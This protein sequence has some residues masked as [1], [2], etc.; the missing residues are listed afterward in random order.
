MNRFVGSLLVSVLPLCVFPT[1]IPRNLWVSLE[2]RTFDWELAS[3][4]GRWT[5]ATEGWIVAISPGKS[6]AASKAKLAS[7]RGVVKVFAM[8]PVMPETLLSQPD[9][10]MIRQTLQSYKSAYKQYAEAENLQLKDRFGRIKIPGTG[11]LEAW[12]YFMEERSFP[13]RSIDWE[14]Y[15]R[16][17]AQRDQMPAATIGRVEGLGDAPSGTWQPVGPKN[18]DVPYRIYWGLRPV[19]GRINGIAYDP[20]DQ[21]VYYVASAGGGVWKTTDAGVNWTPLS[22]GWSRLMTSCVAVDPTNR[23]NVYVGTGDHHG[24]RGPGIG[25][26]KSTNQGLSFAKVGGTIFDANCIADILIDPENPQ[27][28]VVASGRGSAGTNRLYRSVDGG[29][30]F[31]IVINQL[32]SWSDLTMGPNV[33][34]TRVYYAAGGGT[35]GNVWKSTDRGATWTKLT[36]PVSTGSHSCMAIAGSPVNFNNVYLLSPADNN[37]FR[38]LDAGATWTA[39]GGSLPP[40]TSWGQDTYDFHINCSSKLGSVDVVYVGLIDIVQSANGGSSWQSVGGPTP[41]N[42]ALTHNDQHGFAINPQNPDE[43][44]I[45]NDGG[46]YRMT[47]NP[48]ANTWSYGY[49]SKNICVTTFYNGSYHP[50]L[51]DYMMGGTQDN[52]TPTALGDLLNWSNKGGGDGAGTT[53]LQLNGSKQYTMAQYGSPIYRTANLWSTSNTLSWSN[54]GDSVPFIPTAASD[55]SSTNFFYIGSNYLYRYS[56]AT[57]TWANRLGGV[58][59]SASGTIRSIRVAPNNTNRIYTG[60]SDGQMWM[61]QNQ[62]AN[63]T[64]INTGSPGLPTRSITSISVHP[65]NEND[66]IVTVSGTGTGHVWRCANTTAGTR[67]WTNI[68]GSGG[69]GLPDIAHNSVTRDLDDPSGTLYVGCDVGVFMSTNSGA[70]W[71]NATGPLGLPNVHVNTVEAT[72]GTRFLNCATYGRGMWRIPL[73]A[74][75]APT[76]YAVTQGTAL[77]GNLASLALS[78]DN[79]LNVQGDETTPL[80]QIEVSAVAPIASPSKLEV[81]LESSTTRS[82]MV[83]RIELWN[84]T[85][86]GGAGGWDASATWQR[87]G[88]LTDTQT[89]Q[90]VTLNPAQF[91]ASGSRSVRARITFVPN[92]DTTAFDGWAAKFDLWRWIITP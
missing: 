47:Y 68:S 43:V 28:V 79:R 14:A 4:F 29:A 66:V 19:S 57:S 84:Y 62:G 25:L 27:I 22:D 24:N 16:A 2:S 44:L 7:M 31:S 21:N 58:A 12:L 1:E 17:E 86:N 34:G 55:P 6:T 71:A 73:P 83:E 65:T 20:V 50:T 39:I 82:D 42:S 78:D 35:G 53:I 64:Q 63:W 51:K 52:A 67:V 15:T 33:A 11:Y 80:P 13:K 30:T 89:L 60:A 10:R 23:N 5:R 85:L 61:S 69:T 72:A 76:S 37:I 88:T 90:S 40:G 54:T 56:D 26:M 8:A 74:S 46:I 75:I 41:S 36:P 87:S 81:L 92:V 38:S 48:A 49:L 32:V 59:L 45:S 18:L 77:S 70:T 91:I 9:V 3:N